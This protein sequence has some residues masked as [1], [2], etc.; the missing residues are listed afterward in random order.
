MAG[1]T[2]ERLAAYV[3]NGQEQII[4]YAPSLA[5]TNSTKYYTIYAHDIEKD[6]TNITQAT[7]TER[8]I[9]SQANRAK[10][11]KTYGDANHEISPL[12]VGDVAWN[13][14][15][16]MFPCLDEPFMER[17]GIYSWPKWGAGLFMLNK[18]NCWNYYPD[19][20]RTVLTPM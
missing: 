18:T 20:F 9:A 15:Y 3:N 1:G 19:G 7:D 11:T 4:K 2:F 8:D 13:K 12:E 6:N 16:S 5:D 10:N 17:G 14:D